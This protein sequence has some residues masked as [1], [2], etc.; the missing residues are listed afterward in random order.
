MTQLSEQI[1]F[2]GSLEQWFVINI[3]DRQLLFSMLLESSSFRFVNRA[4]EFPPMFLTPDDVIKWKPFRRYWPFVRG[5]HRSPVNTPHKGQWRGA[6][7]FSLT[8]CWINCWINIRE[9][10]DLRRHCAHCDVTVIVLWHIWL[11]TL[12]ARVL[13][14]CIRISNSY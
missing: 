10:G 14:I 3:P 2:I 1:C 13:I 6:L 5:I 11:W 8:Y 4:P 12:Q 7:K 9:A